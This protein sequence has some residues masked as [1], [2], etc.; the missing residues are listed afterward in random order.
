M[1]TCITTPKE[2]L[3]ETLRDPRTLGDDE[4]RGL[5]SEEISRCL[6]DAVG[7]CIST[8]RNTDYIAASDLIQLMH[9]ADID[10]EDVA[11]SLEGHREWYYD[12][13]ALLFAAGCLNDLPERFV[14]VMDRTLLQK[15]VGE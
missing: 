14:A 10:A 4:Y 6:T 3:I 8:A 13:I 11:Q 12:E 2:R 1:G 15:E 9:I 5:S 7:E